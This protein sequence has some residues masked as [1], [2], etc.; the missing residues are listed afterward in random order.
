MPHA[1]SN[2]VKI[3]YHVEGDGPA[4][5]LQHG[6]SGNLHG[7][8]SA[9]YVD[10]LKQ[11]YTLILADTRGHGQS[12]KPHDVESYDMKLKSDDV[13]AALDD[14]GI[15]KAHYIGYS[16]GGR[17]GYG[18]A[19]YAPERFR[20]IIIGGMHPYGSSGGNAGV[21]ERIGILEQGIEEYVAYLESGMWGPM[22][23]D[24]R[25]QMLQNDPQA[26]IASSIELRDF[27]GIEDVLPSM[28]MPCLLLVGEEDF[29]YEGVTRCVKEMPNA[30]MVSFPGQDHGQTFQRSD[31][32]LP[33]I[34]KFLEK[35]T[36]R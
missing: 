24:E 28:T 10:A 36:G 13:V 1:D 29:L 3:H 25:A 19:K 5:I 22:T 34:T 20:S 9:G 23:P 7:W 14:L 12:D 26:L 15:D 33:H 27:Q 2:G 32:T 4:I 17:T 6:F 16:L 11:G 18:V 30:T 35:C 31:L 21:D 8:E